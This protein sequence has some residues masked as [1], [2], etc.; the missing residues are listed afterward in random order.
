MK[1]N[2]K[3][4]RTGKPSS[5]VIPDIWLAPFEIVS[6]HGHALSGPFPWP[7][8]VQSQADMYFSDSP[9]IPPGSSPKTFTGYCEAV[10]A[11]RVLLGLST[12]D[13]YCDGIPIR[14]QI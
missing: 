6:G 2:Y 3:N 5:V 8:F 7:S 14:P 11:Q 1:I 9:C 13:A 10:M 4:P 12:S